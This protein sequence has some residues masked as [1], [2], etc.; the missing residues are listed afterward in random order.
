M[1]EEL[2]NRMASVL[3]EIKSLAN[4]FKDNELT[5]TQEVIEY[6]NTLNYYST[7]DYKKIRPTQ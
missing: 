7:I 4:I 3:S 6:E 1:N 5:N 2:K